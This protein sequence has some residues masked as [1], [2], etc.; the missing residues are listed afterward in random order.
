MIRRGVLL[1]LSGLFFLP[2][3]AQADTLNIAVAANFAKPL[4]HI[5]A[6]YEAQTG[7]AVTIT[8]ASSG[9]LYAQITHGAD[10]DVFL[11]ADAARPERLI[12][13]ERVSASDV[14]SYTT[15]RLGYIQRGSD[16]PDLDSLKTFALSPATRLAIAKPALAPYGEAAK[17]TLTSLVLWQHVSGSL[18]YGNNVLQTYQFFISGNVDHALLAWSLVKDKQGAIRLPASLH[19]PIVQKLA[20]T[21]TTE[22]KAAAQA[23]VDFLLSAD[24]QQQL[25][26]WGYEPVGSP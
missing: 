1:L 9:T 17:Q 23:F 22:N 6:D 13:D 10:I 26:Q 19:Q 4:R 25:S 5:A 2:S 16:A 3:L 8:K 15:G 14:Y 21:A 18:V 20:I 11:S 7:E 24:V 12:E